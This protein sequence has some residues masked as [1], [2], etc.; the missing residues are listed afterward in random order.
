MFSI[1][2]KDGREYA[3]FFIKPD[4]CNKNI[5]LTTNNINKK[6]KKFRL[7]KVNEITIR[8]YPNKLKKLDNIK[9]KPIKFYAKEN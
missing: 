6:S 2:L 3:H 4:K 9:I 8:I 5:Y 7:N 1:S